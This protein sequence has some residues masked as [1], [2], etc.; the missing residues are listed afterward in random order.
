MTVRSR[1]KPLLNC[2]FD[3][4]PLVPPLSPGLRLDFRAD[5]SIG[6][7]HQF[8]GLP[9]P[10]EN[11]DALI[12]SLAVEDETHPPA[13]VGPFLVSKG[14][15]PDRVTLTYSEELR[16]QHAQAGSARNEKTR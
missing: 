14:D 8:F 15:N 3:S 11:G 1:F 9:E 6:K 4:C 5:S 2:L 7:I 13:T 10:E 12:G 16:R